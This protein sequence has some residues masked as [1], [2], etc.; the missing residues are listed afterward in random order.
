ML[1][2]SI[3]IIRLPLDL[4]E[5]RL[6]S[7]KGLL[8]QQHRNGNGERVVEP[9]SLLGQ[10]KLSQWIWLLTVRLLGVGNH[11]KDQMLYD[12]EDIDAAR[13]VPDSSSFIS[14]SVLFDLRLAPLHDRLTNAGRLGC[15]VPEDAD[16]ADVV[17][18]M[19]EAAVPFCPENV[20]L[21]LLLDDWCYTVDTVFSTTCAE[22]ADVDMELEEVS[23]R[24]GSYCWSAK[25]LEECGKSHLP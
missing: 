6:V 3:R 7:H 13:I 14:G 21:D 15:P 2:S 23:D 16:R 4:G 20:S 22:P 5:G 10:V 24:P 25:H 12:D 19:V 9:M 8:G 17:A 1:T 18:F 11:H